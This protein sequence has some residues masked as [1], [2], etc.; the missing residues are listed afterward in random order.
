MSS[1]IMGFLALF[2]KTPRK[3]TYPPSCVR[4]FPTFNSLPK[5]LL[6]RQPPSGRLLTPAEKICLAHFLKIYCY[7]FHFIFKKDRLPP[8]ASLRSACR[9]N[10]L[11][12]FILLLLPVRQRF[13]LL[14]LLRL[15]M[16]V[17]HCPNPIRHYYPLVIISI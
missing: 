1:G 12:F 6:L 10:L 3:A 5:N 4:I 2:E 17:R 16:P 14:R 9:K 13:C 15:I 11:C 8:L 7:C